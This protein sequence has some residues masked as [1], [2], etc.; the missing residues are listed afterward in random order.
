MATADQV[1]PIYYAQLNNDAQEQTLAAGANW[2]QVPLSFFYAT[3]PGVDF[4]ARSTMIRILM[5]QHATLRQDLWIALQGAINRSTL[6]GDAVEV[7]A[8]ISSAADPH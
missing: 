2:E 4:G 5:F 6:A 8:H 1:R 7:I 3:E